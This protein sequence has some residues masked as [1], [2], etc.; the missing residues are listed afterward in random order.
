MNQTSWYQ[1]F[2]NHEDFTDTENV[3]QGFFDECIKAGENCSLSTLSNSRDELME[4]ILGLAE[5]IYDEPLSVYVDNTAWGTLDYAKI[6][7]AAIFPALYKPATWYDL[8]NRLAK[9]HSGNGTDA[10]LAYG[11]SS[12][13]ADMH[14]A[15]KFVTC[16]DGKSGPAHWPQDRR[17][18]L[19]FGM[20]FLNSSLF[21]PTEHGGLYIKQQWPLPQTHD[22]VPKVGVK[23]AHPLLILSTTYDPICPLVSARGAQL[24][25]ADSRLVEVKGFGHC[26]VA[27]TSS[28]LAKHVRGF[29]YNGTLPHS[30]TQCE[31]D[32]PYFV[33]PEEDGKAAVALREF[34]DPE[35]MRIHMAQLE[36][37]RDPDWPMWR[38]W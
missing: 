29:L 20:A 3:L 17:S 32:G 24:D 12:P 2:V 13:W 1:D 19:E 38:R 11:L 28:C 37:A 15:N 9:L 31:V 5:S 16:N 7:Y 14:D 25:F 10:F 30:H 23:T 27:V 18:L 26:S 4:K 35:E 34:E 22:Y 36:L 33:K 8:A 6:V 21:A